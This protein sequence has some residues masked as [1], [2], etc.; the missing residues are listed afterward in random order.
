MW[1]VEGDD[2]LPGVDDSGG[3]Q[4]PLDDLER[5]AAQQLPVL[6]RARLAYGSVDNGGRRPRPRCRLGDGAPLDRGREPGPAATPQAARLQ[7]VDR[8]VGPERLRRR[9]PA[10]APGGDVVVEA[11][12]G[13]RIEDAVDRGPGRGCRQRAPIVAPR[14]SPGTRITG[15]WQ[16]SSRSVAGCRERWPALSPRPMTIASA[17]LRRA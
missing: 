4:R 6:E 1:R 7:F 2:H 12:V 15:R 17:W 11:V 10:S 14:V 3:D 9:Q 16:R 8:P 5:V 13:V